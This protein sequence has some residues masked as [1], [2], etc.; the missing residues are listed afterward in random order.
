[1]VA[2][3]IG[4]PVGFTDL[5]NAAIEVATAYR[6]AGW[7]VRAYLPEQEIAQ[8]SV[9]IQIVEARFGNVRVEGTPRRDSAARLTRI[10]ERA[11]ISGA[12]VNAN[13]LD[14]GL[15]LVGD[16]PGVTVTGTLAEGR[17]EAETDL[18][19]GVADGPLVT[20]DVTADN[21]GAR[22][23]GAARII[24][25]ASL[26]SPLK[27]GDRLDGTFLHSAGSNYERLAYSVP[28]GSD[29]WRVGVNASQLNYKVVT[30]AF[31]AL[32][33]HGTSTTAGLEAKY[34]IV[35]SRLANLYAVFNLDDRRF[36]NDSAG[37]TTTRYT[38]QA[39]SVGLN[40]N[41]FDEFGGG[42]ANTAGVTFEQGHLD[43]EGSP[44]EAADALTTQTAGSF[45]KLRFSAGRQQA[46]T[47]RFSLYAG[48]SGQV[49]SKNLDSSEKLYLGGADG[50]RAY[51]ANEAGGADGVLAD[52][53]A[54]ERLPANFNTVEFVDWGSIRVN[55]N[56]HI[57][58]AAKPNVEDLKGAGV[59]LGWTANF[60]LSLKATISHRIGSNPNPTST[61]DDQDGSLVRNR[62]WLQ[63]SMPF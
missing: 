29:G 35:R 3:F 48:F 36:D 59:S 56:N 45:D 12:P 57:A 63:A 38:L 19:L 23:T 20:G 5:Q 55:E 52:L 10:I 46:V 26:N 6:K 2:R 42:G 40:G 22:A 60:G 51:P 50:V 54:R 31:S 16:T 17:K 27:M 39:A 14:R 13:A 47:E 61:G 44:N 43:L 30:A 37:A 62:V 9:T 58:G 41:L 15:L 1:M 49:A 33:A 11:Q 34:P 25:D 32:D 4:H 24:I 21:A 28:V 53:E 18:V 7:V 8:G